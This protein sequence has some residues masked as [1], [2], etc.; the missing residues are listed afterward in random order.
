MSSN[1]PS[2][3]IS[4][5]PEEEGDAK[6]N[7]FTRKTEDSSL[8]PFEEDHGEVGESK[9]EFENFYDVLLGNRKAVDS[10]EDSTAATTNDY[11]AT[12]ENDELQELYDHL[13]SY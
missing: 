11:N 8:P 1:L 9:E 13:Q 7:N 6:L 10:H 12:T 3:E 4:L 2:D 5:K